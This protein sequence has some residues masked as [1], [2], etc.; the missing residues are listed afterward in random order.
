MQTALP[1][2]A[3]LTALPLVFAGCAATGDGPA[4]DVTLVNLGKGGTGGTGGVGEASFSCILRLQNASPDPVQ[5]VGGAY[6]VYL[7]GIYLGEALTHEAMT[8]GG[9]STAT[10]TVTMNISTFRLAASLYRVFESHK[11]AYRL[12]STVYVQRALGRS[13]VRLAKEGSIDLDALER[14]AGAAPTP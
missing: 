8:V 12:T 2:R 3:F 11:A 5:V 4:L 9:L 7:D 14:P 13:A 10:Q 1:R 6:K